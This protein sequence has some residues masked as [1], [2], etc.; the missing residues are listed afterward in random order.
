[1]DRRW[2]RC[3]IAMTRSRNLTSVPSAPNCEHA[4]NRCAAWQLNECKIYRL[5][6]GRWDGP[7]PAAGSR[8]RL[9]HL[10]L[11]MPAVQFILALALGAEALWYVDGLSQ[12]LSSTAERRLR[13]SRTFRTS[14]LAGC[15]ASFALPQGVRTPAKRPLLLWGGNTSEVP[16]T[17]T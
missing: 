15:A 11:W 16:L 5:P 9:F 8:W 4:S 13:K 17:G 3:L 1:M 10:I 2:R 7:A 12:S 6:R 14:R